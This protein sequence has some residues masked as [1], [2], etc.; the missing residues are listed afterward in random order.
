M[1]TLNRHRSLLSLRSLEDRTN[2]ASASFLAGTLTITPH[3]GDLVTVSVKPAFNSPGFLQATD[4]TTT[5]FSS[6]AAQNVKNVVVNG[7]GIAN[8][9]FVLAGGTQLSNLTVRGAKTATGVTVSP[10]VISGNVTFIG[11]TTGNDTVTL[12]GGVLVGG[13][14]NLAMGGGNNIANLN[15]NAIGGNL[16]VTGSTGNDNVN[17]AA[18]GPLTVGGSWSLSL[19]GGIN[20]VAGQNGQTVRVGKN[21]T[22]NGGLSQDVFNFNATSLI[23]GGSLTATMVNVPTTAFDQLILSNLTIGGNVTYTGSSSNDFFSMNGSANVGG[24]V[25]MTGSSG[26]NQMA[27]FNSTVAG[28]VSY[29]GA[30]GTDVF[31]VENTIVSN[32]MTATLGNDDLGGSVFSLN[33]RARL[34]NASAVA[35]GGN[36]SVT[37]GTATDTISVQRTTLLGNMTLSSGEGSDLIVLDDL[38]VGG[39]GSINL[40]GGNDVLRVDS[41]NGFN[42]VTRFSS[43]FTVQAGAGSD[44]IDLRA[45]GG[46]GINF[47]GPVKLYGGADNDLLQNSPVNFFILPPGS[48][49]E[50]LEVGNF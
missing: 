38:D 47:G 2:P 39:I 16:T 25:T 45:T 43:S 31:D 30:G 49:F 1:T 28:S 13:S 32:N 10:S 5:F 7:A 46:T 29:S 26:V 14:V 20:N 48:Q 17:V 12:A 11:T 42:G 33:Q 34:G 19:G 22:Y 9:G 40:A 41:T 50:D 36:L 37:G 18:N 3:P 15:G 35:I 4:G 27:L 21:L 44:T 8:Y 6:T 24:N 23:V